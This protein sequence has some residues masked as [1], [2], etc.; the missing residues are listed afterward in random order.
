MKANVWVRLHISKSAVQ[1]AFTRF[2]DFFWR[3]T[4]RG[5]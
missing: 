5:R 2:F 3:E 1:R 4:G